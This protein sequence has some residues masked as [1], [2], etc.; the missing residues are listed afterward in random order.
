M[1]AEQALQVLAGRDQQRLAV[2]LLQSPQA[3]PPQA[4]PVLGFGEQWLHPDLAFAHGL[5]V[6]LGGVVAADP[7]EVGLLQAAPHAPAAL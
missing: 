5:G 7:V 2:D 1:P 6:G 4:V 3:E